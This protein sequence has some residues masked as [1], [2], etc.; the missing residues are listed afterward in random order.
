MHC[1]NSL[2]SSSSAVGG[3]GLGDIKMP[4]ILMCNYEHVQF[5]SFYNTGGI[6]GV[7][8]MRYLYLKE[9]RLWAI[10]ASETLTSNRVHV[11]QVLNKELDLY[12]LRNSPA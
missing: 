7:M 5:R 2:I 1:Y 6:S 9:I 10:Q 4:V 3:G 8:F 11:Q 12:H